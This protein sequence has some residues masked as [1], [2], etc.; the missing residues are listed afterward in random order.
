MEPTP[1]AARA[2]GR[3][4][5]VTADRA[6]GIEALRRQVE[7]AQRF[8][9][10]GQPGGALGDL[11]GPGGEQR[12]GVTS[13][14]S[15][16]LM[17]CTVEDRLR[18][19]RHDVVDVE[20]M[21]RRWGSARFRRRGRAGDPRV[22]PPVPGAGRVRGTDHRVR[23]AG[24]GDARR[25][26]GRDRRARP[27][28]ARRRRH[29]GAAGGPRRRG[30]P[31]VVLTARTEVADRVHG[32]ELG[33][34]DYVTKPFSPTEVVLRVQAV[35]HRTRGGSDACMVQLLPSSTFARRSTARSAS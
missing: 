7:P 22:A 13:P 21:W 14:A 30:V 12:P 8:E 5:V 4:G 34:D 24:A 6:S 3:C 10:G 9:P 32:L 15:L 29:R 18:G 1:H 26:P 16:L 33:A 27:W 19:C 2:V 17:S 35:L 11:V 31:V 25:G 28:P 23:R 20:R